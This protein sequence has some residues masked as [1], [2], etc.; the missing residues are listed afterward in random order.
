[1]VKTALLRAVSHDLRSPLTAISAAADAVGSPSLS[2]QERHEMAT[3]IQQE[4]QRLSRL[5]DNLLDLSRLEAG[6]AGPS[7]PRCTSVDEVIRAALAELSP[8]PEDFSPS[9][10]NRRPTARE[11]QTQCSWSARS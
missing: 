10:I 1:M 5:V 2:E 8:A 11:R 7:T 3:L 9:T 4:T 6:A